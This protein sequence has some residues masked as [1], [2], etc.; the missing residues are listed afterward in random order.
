[1]KMV[2]LSYNIAEDEEMMEI[3]EQLGIRS[4]TKWKEVLDRSE[5]GHPRLG[6]HVWPGVNS[7]LATAI[8]DD[9]AEVLF[10]E[11]EAFNAGRKYEDEKVKAFV[12]EVMAAL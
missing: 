5:T 9:K 1:M 4:Y 11:I 2:F 12:W 3:L 8:D 6:T 10:R 7:A